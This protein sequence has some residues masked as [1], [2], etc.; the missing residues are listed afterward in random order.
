[1]YTQLCQLTLTQSATNRCTL[2]LCVPQTYQYHV[3]MSCGGCKNAV[4]RIMNSVP[5]V[6]HY[7]ADIATQKVTVS[8][9]MD[10]AD[11]EEKL[12]KWA[13][14]ANKEVKFLQELH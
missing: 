13:A 1:M 2:H 10:R 12:T 3:S 11:L 7:E 5:G 9:L 6:K 8:G 14:A 4:G